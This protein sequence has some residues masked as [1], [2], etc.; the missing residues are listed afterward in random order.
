MEKLLHTGPCQNQ[1]RSRPRFAR[2][3]YLPKLNRG[4]CDRVV[5]GQTGAKVSVARAGQAAEPEVKEMVA[6]DS[7]AGAGKR[8]KRRA[9][10]SL[11][12]KDNFGFG[13]ICAMIC[14]IHF[15]QASP[16]GYGYYQNAKGQQD[17]NTGGRLKSWS[18]GQVTVE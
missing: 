9:Q 5:V 2:R 3:K 15:F 11:I 16:G 14:N 12:E 1:N 8:F 17:T 7:V 10:S 4:V 18:P 13:L 6:A